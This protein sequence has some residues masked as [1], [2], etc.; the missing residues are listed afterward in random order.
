MINNF[1]KKVW[2]ICLC[3]VSLSLAWCF[4]IPDEDWLPSKNKTDS[5][6]LQK[7][8]EFEQAINSFID[9]IDMISSQS[10]SIENDENDEIN[11]EEN[12]TTLD[13]EEEIENID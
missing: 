13:T 2:I 1:T 7:D 3:L 10:N 12:D 11:S 5:W 6:N 8:T 9:W 4:H